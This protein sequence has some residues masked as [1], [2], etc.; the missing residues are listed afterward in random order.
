MRCVMTRD[1]A[2]RLDRVR[3][4][5]VLQPSISH[6]TPSLPQEGATSIIWAAQEGHLEALRTLLIAGANAAAADIVREGM[7]KSF[8]P[9]TL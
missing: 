6:C 7:R 2:E 8:S 5:I 3:V 4:D 9:C 1:R